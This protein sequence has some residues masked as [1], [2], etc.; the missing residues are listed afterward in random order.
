MKPWLLLGEICLVVGALMFC[1]GTIAH[2]TG[3]LSA[4]LIVTVALVLAGIAARSSLLIVFAVLAA[5]VCLGAH[6]L[7]PR[8][9]FAGYVRADADGGVVRWACVGDL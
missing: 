1:R 4:M 8:D 6:R 3:S 7:R 9:V 5:Q 2:G